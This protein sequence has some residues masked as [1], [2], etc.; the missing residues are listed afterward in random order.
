[1]RRGPS[2][3]KALLGARAVGRSDREEADLGLEPRRVRQFYLFVRDSRAV[4]RDIGG[5]DALK[6]KE[7]RWASAPCSIV[8]RA[9]RV[10][11]AFNVVS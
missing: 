10:G 7:P 4:G 9:R 11:R 2:C 3:G 5:K 6:G 1:M 8:T